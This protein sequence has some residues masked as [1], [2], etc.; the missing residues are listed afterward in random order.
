VTDEQ[1]SRGPVYN[2]FTSIFTIGGFWI[3][4]IVIVSTAFMA[5]LPRVLP[6][7]ATME[8]WSRDIRVAYDIPNQPQSQDIVFVAFTDQTLDLP[9]FPYRLPIDRSYMANLIRTLESYGA[10]AIGID[11]LFDRWTEPEKDAD[12]MDALHNAQIPVV[13]IWGNEIIGVEGTRLE[14]LQQMVGDNP[15]G[16]GLLI[17]DRAD[18]TVRAHDPILDEDG[19]VRVSFPVALAEAAGV[20]PANIPTG[21]HTIA[22]R[23]SPPDASPPFPEYP[24][25]YVQ[26]LPPEW[27][28]GKIVLIGVDLIDIDR[29]RTP[30]QLLADTR[31]IPG[32]LVHAHVLDQMLNNRWITETPGWMR[33]LILLA[34]AGIGVTIAIPHWPLWIKLGIGVGMTLGYLALVG[35]V[36][37]NYLIMLPALMPGFSLLLAASLG[38]VF[39]GRQERA[40]RAYIRSAFSRY[41]APAVVARLDKNP[42]ALVLGG[43]RREVTFMFSDLQGFTS[44]SEKLTP[45][46]LADVINAYLDGAGDIIL[47]HGGTIDKFIGDGIMSFF[48]APEAHD[49]D[50]DRTVACALEFD[51]FSNKFSEEWRKKGVPVGI[52]RIGIHTG[53]AIVGNFGG[54]QRFDY[55]ALGDVVNAA[56][57]MEGANKQFGTHLLVSEETRKLTHRA[58]FRPV[59]DIVLV[60]KDE[61]IPCF[62]PVSETE[63]ASK[64]IKKYCE[65]FE[66]I[67]AESPKALDAFKALSEHFPDDPLAAY[68]YKRLQSGETGTRIVLT[69]K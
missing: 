67:R 22:W 57:R 56:S 5:T 53:Q 9:Q 4:A 37:Y 47:K 19:P 16:L 23:G 69:S 55:T 44:M 8:Q 65:D 15:T 32:I 25:Q 50:P 40:K 2:L 11:I 43:E 45:S 49:D 34:M 6:I 27:F 52:T 63:F 58:H 38:S 60:G 36:Y 10:R 35:V 68:H 42:D 31:P 61:A 17:H 33:I 3:A 62:E 39:V 20:D 46:E 54:R 26:A 29:H 13:P 48:G 41:I 1:Q 21:R 30:Q 14:I 18:G 7:A 12:L 59:G 28:A 64:R 24:A 51:A 66:L